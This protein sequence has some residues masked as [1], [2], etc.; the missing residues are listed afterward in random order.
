MADK[1]KDKTYI[2]IRKGFT[3]D[4]FR[5]PPSKEPGSPPSKDPP[6][7]SGTDGET[8]KE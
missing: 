2:D 1:D 5:T 3:I 6:P 8:K 7:S 4:N